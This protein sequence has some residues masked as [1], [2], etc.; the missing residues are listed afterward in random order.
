MT[1]MVERGCVMKGLVA[2]LLVAAAQPVHAEPLPKWEFGLGGTAFTLPDYRG[3]DERRGYLLPL[4]FLVYRGESVR[5][6]RQAVRCTFFE[7]NPV[8]PHL[9]P[10]GTP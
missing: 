4:P 2:A 9:R 8:R 5:C 10:C 3:S 7:S 6:D 1:A